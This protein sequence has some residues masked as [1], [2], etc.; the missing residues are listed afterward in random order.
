MCYLYNESN[1][2]RYIFIFI[3]IWMK[4]TDPKALTGSSIVEAH[5]EGLACDE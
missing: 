1:L 5:D 2:G 3:E 4:Y